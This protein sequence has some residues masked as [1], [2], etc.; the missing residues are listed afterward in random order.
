LGDLTG[1]SRES[2]CRILTEFSQDGII[3]QSGKEISI[4]NAEKL[5]KISKNG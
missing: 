2:V 5:E 3:S 4:I 1:T